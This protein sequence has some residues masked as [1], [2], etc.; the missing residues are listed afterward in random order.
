[1]DKKYSVYRGDAKLGDFKMPPLDSPEG[2]QPSGK[3]RNA[4]NVA[5]LLDKP[6]LVTGEPGT[7]KTLLAASIG[8]DLGL[9]APLEFVAKTNSIARDL[10]YHYDSLRHFHDAN[11]KKATDGAKEEPKSEKERL[12][13]AQQE[14]KPYIEFVG[15]GKAIKLAKEEG[16]RSVVLIDEIDKAPRDFPNDMLREIEKMEFKVIET[17]EVISAPKD[18][19]PIVVVTSNSERLLP[20]AFLRRCVYYHI[21]FPDREELMQIVRSRLKDPQAA[22]AVHYDDK[23]LYWLVDHFNMV[24]EVCRKKDPATAELLAWIRLLD[25]IG[26]NPAVQ[27]P[28]KDLL[29]LSYSALAKHAEDLKALAENLEKTTLPD[30]GV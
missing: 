11:M 12:E 13:Q 21:E 30:V 22:E 9:G 29:L 15:L 14:Y 6:L 8:Q 3:L 23:Q 24:R 27:P 10:F 1:M 17:G 18:M 2:Y 7:G 19:K 25:T 20:D 4:V 28:Q 26:F 16:K 5:I